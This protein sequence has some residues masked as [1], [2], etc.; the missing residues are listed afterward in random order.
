MAYKEELWSEAK[1][2]TGICRM[3]KNGHHKQF[4]IRTN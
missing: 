1:K 2:N 3:C 4:E